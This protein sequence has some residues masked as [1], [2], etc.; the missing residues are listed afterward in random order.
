MFV[1]MVTTNAGI[2]SLPE[3]LN[4]SLVYI[5]CLQDTV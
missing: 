1:R 3:A 5:H 4:S 2:Y